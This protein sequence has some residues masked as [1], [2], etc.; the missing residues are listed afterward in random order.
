MGKPGQPGRLPYLQHQRSKTGRE[1]WYVRKGRGK[2]IR[3][4]GAYG[5][6]EFMSAYTA[7]I[8]VPAQPLAQKVSTDTMAYL[9][10]EYRASHDFTS[11]SPATRYQ[12]EF[13]LKRLEETIGDQPFASFSTA[14]IQ[15]AF[16]KR[17]DKPAQARH[18][19]ECLKALFKLAKRRDWRKDDP[20]ADVDA[21]ISGKKTEGFA[22][23][24]AEDL[25]AYEAKWP[26]GTR[27]RLMVDVL[28]YSGFRRSDAF[29]FGPKHIRDG[30]ITI[31]TQ[32]TGTEVTMS[33]LPPL[34]ASIEA[35][36]V[37]TETFIATKSG[38]PFTRESFGN[39]FRKAAQAAGVFKPLHGL[40]KAAAE[41]A[42][43]AGATTNELQ[44]LFGW[45]NVAM[46]NHYTKMAERKGLGLAA[47]GKLAAALGG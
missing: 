14:E 3:I 37:G 32:K 45:T 20:T 29:R 19:F 18:W 6:D 8:G 30:V 42:A 41:R 9:I 28:L 35:G 17:K 47:S 38:K 12:R 5:S 27:E 2:R 36:P 33:L 39:T 21:K 15:R 34:K 10:A 46:A 7:A 11:K 26:V 44:S 16:D 1:F 4:P 24:K 25:A 23:W 31:Q 13:H 43:L 40:R 22:P